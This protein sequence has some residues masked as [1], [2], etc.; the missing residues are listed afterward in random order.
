MK[1]ASKDKAASK[2][3]QRSSKQF[4]QTS[5]F[6]EVFFFFQLYYHMPIFSPSVALFEMRQRG[7]EKC[8][9]NNDGV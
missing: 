9:A 8:L 1:P 7:V 2:V 3:E 4:L 5:N 6:R